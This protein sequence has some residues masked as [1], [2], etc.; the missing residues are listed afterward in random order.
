V[1]D[2]AP[3]AI[4]TFTTFNYINA[5]S[6]SLAW[7]PVAGATRYYLQAT[8]DPTF[9]SIN[10]VDQFIGNVTSYPISS[11]LPGIAYYYKVYADNNICTSLPSD[12][13][14]FLTSAIVWEGT[15][16]TDWNVPQNWS[17]FLVPTISTDIE[18]YDRVNDPIIPT[19]GLN[20]FAY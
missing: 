17:P 14:P 2:L 7:N 20:G 1:A 13:T 4:P 5:N 11:I 16:S 6:V 18:I 8:S 12:I 3:I 10:I 19:A 9:G 15:V